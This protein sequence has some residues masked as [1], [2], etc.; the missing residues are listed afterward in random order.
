MKFYEIL[1]MK[2]HQGSGTSSIFNK[3]ELGLSD[4]DIMFI[5]SHYPQDFSRPGIFILPFL[6]FLYRICFP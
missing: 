2:A 4:S 3:G 5:P 6:K 1:D